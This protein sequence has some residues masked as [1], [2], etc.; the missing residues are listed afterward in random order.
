M[1]IGVMLRSIDEQGGIGVYTRGILDELL[2]QDR[3]DDFVLLYRSRSS[4][5][6][7]AGRPNVSERWVRAPNK[8][9]WDQVAVPLACRRERIDVLFHPKF[10]V[11]VM[12]PCPSVMVVHGA[13][14]FIPEQA[15]FYGRFDVAQNRLMMPLYFRR[16]AAVISVT[17]L[18]TRN[19]QQSLG[20][21]ADRV[22]TIYFA[23]A[24]HFRR[25][26]DAAVLERVRRKYCLPSRFIL[27][28]SKPGGGLRKNMDGI[29]AAYRLCHGRIPQKLV[30]GGAGCEVF[31]RQ[32]DLP[33]E[34]YGADVVFTG[35]IDQADL[36][37][38]YSLADLYLYPSRLESASIPLMEAM[39]CGAPIVTSA[40]NDLQDVA[41][42][43]AVLVDPE[44]P[45]QIAAAVV[46]V[47]GDPGLQADLR[48]RGLARS[49]RFNWERCG[50]E[51]LRVIRAAARG[52]A[53]AEAAPRSVPV[54][55]C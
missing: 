53:P 10:S 36:P 28:L 8:A 17:E 11:P 54:G 34:G 24:K 40:A 35:W 14:W 27:T 20:P 23:P 26:G 33:G 49:R 32:H 55:G 29:L 13:D 39:A 9:W 3:E 30:V 5:G 2:D 45:E 42:G 41:G 21:I 38:I 43:A 48:E 15:R 37:A 25:V 12:A 44:E 31:R 46:R 47:L 4:L 7:Y 6:R 18:T 52:A 19:F 51:T 16:A 50:R 22:T 1:R